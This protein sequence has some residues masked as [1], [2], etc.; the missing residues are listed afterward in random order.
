METLYPWYSLTRVDGIIAQEGEEAIRD[1]LSAH[2][3]GEFLDAGPD[4]ARRLISLLDLARIPNRAATVLYA[5]DNDWVDVLEAADAPG[6][7]FL[8]AFWRN[9]FERARVA[10]SGRCIS[11]L[12]DR[13]GDYLGE[14]GGKAL[15]L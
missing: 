14:C 11:W 8:P 10:N 13:K 2:W 9:A 4:V 5:V 6:C 12:L 1:W 7:G 15:E 3:G